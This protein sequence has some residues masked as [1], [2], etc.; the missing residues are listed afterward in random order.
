MNAVSFDIAT[1]LGANG[2]GTFGADGS[3][4]AFA[5]NEK[6]DEQIL[7]MGSGNIPVPLK[8][9]NENPRFQILVRGKKGADIN[10]A[11]GVIDSIHRFLIV[12]ARQTINLTEY[13]YYEP[14]TGIISLGR[15]EN[16]RYVF[17]SNYYTF[18]ES[19]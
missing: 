19:I 14:V 17:S 7:I 10:T 13:A 18:R 4:Y 9:L 15:D 5:W 2:F 8:E 11:Y 6:L 3:I 16:D 1:M 12:Q